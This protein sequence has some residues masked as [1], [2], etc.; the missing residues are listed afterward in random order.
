MKHVCNNEKNLRREY[1][2]MSDDTFRLALYSEVLYSLMDQ[3]IDYISK[4]AESVMDY[5]VFQTD[6]FELAVVYSLAHNHPE[7][8]K[9]IGFDLTIIDDLF[10]EN[11]QAR[12]EH[13]I[14]TTDIDFENFSQ[15]S[16]Y[17]E[18]ELPLE[19]V[20]ADLIL[21]NLF[22][23]QGKF[24]FLYRYNAILQGLPYEEQVDNLEGFVNRVH[25]KEEKYVNYNQLVHST[26]TLNKKFL[27]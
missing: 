17:Y 4:D 20:D 14:I 22:V 9:E 15:F 18:H 11:V 19:N 25:D 1:S 6:A 23:M 27:N 24:N 2:Q 7:L 16:R 12:I 13:E 5:S 21:F 26:K 10:D 8:F 3:D